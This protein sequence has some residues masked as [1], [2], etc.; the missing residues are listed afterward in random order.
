MRERGTQDAAV[1]PVVPA[2]YWRYHGDDPLPD[3]ERESPEQYCRRAAAERSERSSK[4]GGGTSEGSRFAEPV[5]RGL[6][7]AA[8][9]AFAQNIASEFEACHPQSDALKTGEAIQRAARRT[10]DNLS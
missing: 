10:A 8:L 4:S 3:F 9:M 6:L 1:G 7:Y 5:T 2:A